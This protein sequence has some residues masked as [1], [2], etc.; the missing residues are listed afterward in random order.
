MPLDSTPNQVGGK[1]QAEMVGN[2]L[3]SDTVKLTAEYTR[4]TMY[5]ELYTQ[6]LKTNH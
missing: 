1:K 6:T 5:I 2:H 3:Q 4:E